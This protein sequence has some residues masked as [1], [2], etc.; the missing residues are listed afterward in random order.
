VA[1]SRLPEG[2]ARPADRVAHLKELRRSIDPDW[3]TMLAESRVENCDFAFR[4][5][6][7]WHQ[8]E[9]TADTRVRHCESCRKDVHYCTTINEARAHAQRGRCVAINI[10]V[11]RRPGDLPSSGEFVGELALGRLEAPEPPRRR[12]GWPWPRRG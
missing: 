4:C 3:L 5:P 8:L 11:S 6:Q 1:L 10:A 9:L 2:Q 12:W 7:K